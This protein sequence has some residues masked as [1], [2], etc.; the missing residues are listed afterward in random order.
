VAQRTRWV[1]CVCKFMVSLRST[2]HSG[3]EAD[4]Q[5]TACFIWRIPRVLSDG[6]ADVA[7]AIVQF[8]GGSVQATLIV[9]VGVVTGLL[10]GKIP[11]NWQ[12]Y[13]HSLM[14]K[15]YCQ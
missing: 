12:N 5:G 11:D 8:L 15:R 10:V 9:M 14:R 2:S 13:D 4:E 1:L 7:V 6:T 3:L